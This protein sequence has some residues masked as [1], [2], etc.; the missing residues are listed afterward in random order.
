MKLHPGQ[1]VRSKIDGV[2]LCVI[3]E[4]SGVCTC[5]AKTGD[6]PIKVPTDVLEPTGDDSGLQ[7][8]LEQL[9]SHQD[10]N[11]VVLLRNKPDTNIIVAC[12]R[13]PI[14][15]SDSSSIIAQAN[16]QRMSHDFSVREL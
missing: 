7:Y 4:D 13:S 12:R 5:Y 14:S 6:Q 1:I 10:F 9:I 2:K 8:R 11:G 3:A 16:Q 15:T